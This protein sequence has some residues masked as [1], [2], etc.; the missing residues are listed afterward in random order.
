M[1][2]MK[3]ASGLGLR[4]VGGKGSKYGDMGIFVR[5]LEEGGA[6]HKYVRLPV[7]HGLV[8][9]WCL[10]FHSSCKEYGILTRSHVIIFMC[11][12]LS[13]SLHFRTFVGRRPGDKASVCIWWKLKFEKLCPTFSNSVG[14]M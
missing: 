3:G 11:T 7:A 14:R 9:I 12:R 10:L 2:I 6:A 1:H 8:P 4:I 5:N 13:G